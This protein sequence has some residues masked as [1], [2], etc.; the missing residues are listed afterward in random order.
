MSDRARPSLLALSVGLLVGCGAEG[1]IVRARPVR[2]PLE[3]LG[4]AGAERSLPLALAGDQA[5]RAQEL[6]LVVHG[7]RDGRSGSLSINGRP[8]VALANETVAVA[9]PADRFGG[10][11][12]PLATIELSL[13]LS[14]GALVGGENQLRF[15]FEPGAGPGAAIG[16]RVLSVD[17]RDGDRRSVLTGAAFAEEDPQ[18]WRAPRPS[19]DDVAAGARL[20]REAPL[21]FPAETAGAPRVRI[22]ARCGD[23]HTRDGRDLQYFAFSNLAIVERSKLYGLSEIEGEQ[24]ASYVRGLAVPRAGRPWNPPYQPGPGLDAAAPDRWAA[25]SGRGAVLPRDEEGLARLFPPGDGPPVAA[26]GHLSLREH[27]IA[28]PLPTWSQWLPPVHPQDGWGAAFAEGDL[29]RAY[30]ELRAALLST[31]GAS[32]IP[33]AVERLWNDWGRAWHEAFKTPRA[34]GVSWTPALRARHRAVG[35]WHLVKSW[36]LVQEFGLEALAAASFAPT[37]EPRTWFGTW[38]AASVD[39]SVYPAAALRAGAAERW[40]WI[41]AWTHLGAVLNPGNRRRV[42]SGP[43]VW[44]Y[45]VLV[46][47]DLLEETRHPEPARLVALV[48]KAMQES[49][50]G[51]GPDMPDRGWSF[52][53]ADPTWLVYPA[54]DAAWVNVPAARRLQITT[55]VVRAW[56]DESRRYP[57]DRYARHGSDDFA[58]E[59]TAHVPRPSFEGRMADRL[60]AAIP[61][62]RALEME[63]PLLR[64]L[65]DWG[66]AMWP[67]GDWSTLRE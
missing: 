11:G 34:A 3:V 8:P 47:K 32:T 46:L 44:R 17:V 36:E 65:V 61:R 53:L 57:P 33:A 63:A 18:S 43:T 55:A 49:T 22:A 25:G 59:G 48:I 35:Q 62:F 45:G 42:R 13:P 23:C 12:G 21:S 20:W 5:A 58:V 28:L 1:D 38:T 15:R 4:A 9:P 51:I 27:P 6:R 10:I 7:L 52:E 60:R 39:D 2:L 31:R 14:D 50:N 26:S 56:L 16:Y 40:Y 41:N 64:E 24:I 19:P 66:A 29:P 30:G 54:L 67:A 37:G